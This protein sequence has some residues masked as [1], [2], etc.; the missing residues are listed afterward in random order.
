MTDFIKSLQS[1]DALHKEAESWL[2]DNTEVTVAAS[3]SSDEP[4]AINLASALDHNKQIS[5]AM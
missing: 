5:P 3:C 1:F 2:S 4:V